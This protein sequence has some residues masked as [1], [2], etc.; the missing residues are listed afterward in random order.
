MSDYLTHGSQEFYILGKMCLKSCQLSGKFQCY[1]PF[2][3]VLSKP[4][5][6]KKHQHSKFFSAPENSEATKSVYAISE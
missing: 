2:V 6:N 4:K 5:T 1:Q 3:A